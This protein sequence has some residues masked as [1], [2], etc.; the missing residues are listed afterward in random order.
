MIHTDMIS[1]LGDF[2][3]DTCTVQEFT[4]TY[5]DYNEPVKSW[6]D[7]HTDV[8]CAIGQDTQQE[9]KMDDKTVRNSTHRIILKGQY[10]ASEKDR[11]KVGSDY[12]D[13][14]LATEGVRG[15][16]TSLICEKVTV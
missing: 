3:P 11:V 13:I 16:K 12:Y 8:Y 9:I 10:D 1:S 14:L 7:K 2:F 5:N 6:T 4:T 15:T